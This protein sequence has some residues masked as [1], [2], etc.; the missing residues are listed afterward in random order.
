MKIP[1][2]RFGRTELNIPVLSLG[3][4]RFQKSWTELD[5]S[6]ISLAEQSRV[7]RLISQA[8]SYGFD[9]VETARHYGTSELQLGKAITNISNSFQ[10]IQTT[11]C[12]LIKQKTFLLL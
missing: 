2:R 6:E 1:R 8:I 4:M 5:Q 12:D 10:I 7:E 3:G 11:K 9:H